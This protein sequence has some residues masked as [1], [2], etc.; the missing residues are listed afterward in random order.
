MKLLY[1]MVSVILVTIFFTTTLQAQSN[2]ELRSTLSQR[3]FNDISFFKGDTIVWE[4]STKFWMYDISDPANPVELGSNYIPEAPTTFGEFVGEYFITSTK[5]GQLNFYDMSDPFGEIALLS[6]L[7]FQANESRQ[8]DTKMQFHLEGNILF[9]G[10]YDVAT[11][12]MIIDLSDPANPE[13]VSEIDSYEY[14]Y[15]NSTVTLVLGD[16]LN[17]KV[18]DDYIIIADEGFLASYDISNITAPQQG[19]IWLPDRSFEEE[20]RDKAFFH[21]SSV[22]MFATVD[23]DD[24]Y[25]RLVEVSIK[26]PLD[27]L[28]E[29]RDTYFRYHT[30]IYYYDLAMNDR[31]FIHGT[32]MIDISRSVEQF[33]VTSRSDDLPTLGIMAPNKD[34]TQIVGTKYFHDLEQSGVG[35]MEYKNGTWA[36]SDFEAIYRTPVNEQFIHNGLNTGALINPGIQLLDLSDK[37]NP[38]KGAYLDPD[39]GHEAH[40]GFM[41]ENH[42]YTTTTMNINYTRLN[43]Y[44][45]SDFQNPVL[46]DSLEVDFSFGHNSLYHNDL[47]LIGGDHGAIVDFKDPTSPILAWKDTVSYRDSDSDDVHPMFYSKIVPLNDTLYFAYGDHFTFGTNLQIFSIRPT[48]DGGYEPHQLKI[49]NL[50]D[51]FIEIENSDATIRDMAVHGNYVYIALNDYFA[52]FNSIVYGRVYAFDFSDP[53]NPTIAA[54][55]SADH[56]QDQ[57]ALST[58]DYF[59]TKTDSIISV[60]STGGLDN[61]TGINLAGT[62]RVKPY[63]SQIS[64]LSGGYIYESSEFEINIYKNVND[65]P[66]SIVDEGT[67]QRLPIDFRLDPAYPNPFNPSVTIPF[68]LSQTAD[69]SMKV[70]NVTG[71]QV[72]ILTDQRFTAGQHTITWQPM[73]LSSGLYMIRMQINH[74]ALGRSRQA[75][76]KVMFLK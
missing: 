4:S 55:F 69:V 12:I 13:L 33:V 63:D 28:P 44:D 6:S 25:D 34:T 72:A 46:Q 39:D 35:M 8:V 48:T 53:L 75:M 20:I 32:D 60:Y 65:N 73:H 40:N 24:Y 26:N 14:P 42:L 54:E 29:V 62:M 41:V 17:F 68:A 2:L 71:Q 30:Y 59:Y 61:P 57:I 45:V 49:F 18:F 43:V 21:G 56:H 64:W 27:S 22:Y 47:I 16:L 9:A 70:Y 36:Y 15:G 10:S 37:E 11:G 19:Q 58:E 51:D 1:Y 23:H 7:K 38:Q 31:I 67:E 74:K 50:I 66:T 76:Q 3:D 52:S 5:D